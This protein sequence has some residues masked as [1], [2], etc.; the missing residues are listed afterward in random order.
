MKRPVIFAL[1]ALV[2]LPCVAGA[3]GVGVGA[4]GGVSVPIVQDDNG[5]G[6]LFG[7]RVPVS[8][9]PLVTVEPF[10]AK[11]GG[12]DK[13]QDLF[14]G[15][16]T[17]SGIDV[18]SFGANVLLTFGGKLQLYPFAGIGSFKMKRT[19]LDESKTGYNFG[20]G[21]GISPAP[22]ISLHVRGEL[23]AAVDGDVSRKWANVTAGVSYSA[24]SFPAP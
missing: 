19:G 1:L 17:R 23:A 20:L 2:L 10:F 15:T 5:Q 22:K 9:I 18:T 16:I 8:L 14:G 12:G 21:L 3:A 24:F 13:D 7:V 6:T 4:F 11:T